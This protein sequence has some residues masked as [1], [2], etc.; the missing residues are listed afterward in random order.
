M[1]VGS[2][3]ITNLSEAQRYP[4]L[5]Y[6]CLQDIL[7]RGHETYALPSQPCPAGTSS[8]TS[9]LIVDPSAPPH[10]DKSLVR[11]IILSKLA[12]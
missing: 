8:S 11:I 10:I 1:T 4:G 12:A 6:T 7:T 5:R 2:P 3:T 9:R